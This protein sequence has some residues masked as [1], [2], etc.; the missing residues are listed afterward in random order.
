[1][2][3]WAEA[4]QEALTLPGAVLGEAHEGSPAVWVHTKQFAR[5]RWDGDREVLQVWV[6]DRALVAAYVEEDRA[7]Y[8]SIPGYSPLVV[9]CTL[10]RL[11]AA[12]V[13]ELLVE[14]WADRAPKRLVTAHADLR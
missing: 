13:R 3:T 14:S 2:A 1:M 11:E 10:D 4:E 8:R 6:R 7:T 9:L 12:I 5:L